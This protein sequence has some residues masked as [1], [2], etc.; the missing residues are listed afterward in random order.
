MEPWVFKTTDFGKTWTRIV[1]PEA[2]RPR[3]RPRHQGGRGLAALLFV[4]TELGLWIFARR[5]RKLGRSSRAASFPASPYAS[6]QVHPRDHDLVIATHGRGIWIIDDLTPLRGAERRALAQ[7]TA[8]LPT[9]P[10][11]A[12]HA[13]RGR[14]GRKATPAFVGDNP[15]AGAV[16]TYYQRARHI[17]GSLKLE[18][19]D[20]QGKLV[21]TLT[22]SKRRGHQPRHLDMRVKPPARPARGPGR[23]QRGRGAARR[24]RHLHRAAHPRRRRDRDQARDRARSPRALHGRRPQGAVRCRRCG[25]TSCSAR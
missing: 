5:R 15:P 9:P 16:I 3:L 21:D 4:G 13:C 6:S 24:A 22:P 25:P 7:P 10:R 2:G 1:A 17:F 8:F 18:V 11:A 14:L 19:L 12:A 20:G 23:V